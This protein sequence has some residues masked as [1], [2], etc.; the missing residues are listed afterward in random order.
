MS[1]TLDQADV[2]ASQSV[3]NTPQLTTIFSRLFSQALHAAYTAFL[4]Q[5]A[6]CY[7]IYTPPWLAAVLQSLCGRAKASRTR[8]PREQDKTRTTLYAQGECTMHTKRIDGGIL[9]SLISC[10]S[11]PQYRALQGISSVH[12]VR[13]GLN[14]ETSLGRK[15]NCSIGNLTDQSPAQDDVQFVFGVFWSAGR[16]PA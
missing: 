5:P 10:T 3:L 2:Q 4:S 16:Q 14:E 1:L 12:R 13:N 15:L 9:E 6:I 8:E 7:C 11:Q